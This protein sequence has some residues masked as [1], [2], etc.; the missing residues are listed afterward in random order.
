MVCL[1]AKL[2]G[3][4]VVVWIIFYKVLYSF[5][6]CLFLGLGLSQWYYDLVVAVWSYRWV[7][8]KAENLVSAVV[9]PEMD[10]VD[11]YDLD[12]SRRLFYE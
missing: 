11:G 12:L 10:A 8:H 4:T 6:S 9:K 1:T 7:Q 3:T 2:T 5:P